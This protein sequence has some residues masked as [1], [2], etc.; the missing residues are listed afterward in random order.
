[1]RI[2]KEDLKIFLPVAII[3]SVGAY[4]IYHVLKKK[5]NTLADN[6]SNKYQ[7]QAIP[8][9]QIQANKNLVQYA[10]TYYKDNLQGQEVFNKDLKIW[11]KF[12]SLGKGKVAYGGRKTPAKMA[13]LQGIKSILE[14]AE[15][16]NFGPRKA[17]DPKN[18][19]GYLNFKAKVRIN[20]KIENLRI[21][22]ILRQDGKF[23]YNHEVNMKLQ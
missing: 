13:V 9:I 18:I 23:Y 22:I 3:V 1:M 15:Y 16:N 21:A 7:Q 8:D 10:T 11:I 17:K 2:T 4:E 12:T 5:N 20:G 19:V 14:V 6:N